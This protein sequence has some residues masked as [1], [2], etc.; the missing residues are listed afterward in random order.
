[1]PRLGLLLRFLRFYC[2]WFFRLL[3]LFFWF[4]VVVRIVIR[5]RRPL[6]RSNSFATLPA[7]AAPVAL[8][9]PP[10]VTQK[11]LLWIPCDA[12][13]FQLDAIQLLVPSISSFATSGWTSWG[14]SVG[15][16]PQARRLFSAELAQRCSGALGYYA[17]AELCLTAELGWLDAGQCAQRRAPEGFS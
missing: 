14:F 10:F 4:C 6:R 16:H 7:L 2:R 5:G 17:A 8:L 12:Q 11:L 9:T 15:S 13:L 1:M 3:L